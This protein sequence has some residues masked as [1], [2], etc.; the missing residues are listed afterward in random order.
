MTSFQTKF[1]KQL[2]NT[3]NIVIMCLINKK[4]NDGFNYKKASCIYFN[5][6]F[7]LFSVL[8]FFNNDLNIAILDQVN[9]F[10]VYI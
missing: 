4:I 10:I 7:I 8:I 6:N 1:I 2:N 5:S 3:R 9:F